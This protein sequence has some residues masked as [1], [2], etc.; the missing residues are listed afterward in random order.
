MIDSHLHL[1]ERGFGGTSEPGAEL[2]DYLELR[3]R[4]GISR[5]LVVGYEGEERFA[6]NND[7][8]CRLARE[9]DWIVPLVYLDRAKVADQ[10]DL[11]RTWLEQGAAGW[12]S[13]VIG[14]DA[15]RDWAALDDAVWANLDAHA[16]WSLNIDPAALAVLTPRLAGLRHTTVL[17]SHL[18]LPGRAAGS[19]AERLA[20]VIG[21]VRAGAHIR[22]KVSG[23]YAVAG[24]DEGAPF[25]SA[26]P[27]LRELRDRIGVEHLVWGSDYTP[28]LSRQDFA[29]Q[30]EISAYGVFSDT[31]LAV[32][33]D[34]DLS[35]V[36]EP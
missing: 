20:P 21:A 32:L 35:R 33:A 26:T 12:T 27:Y 23:L 7:Y 30:V 14:A 18:G 17:L 36:L 29:S 2:A 6:G 13:Y 24:P 10:P 9:Q 31:E 4:H 8:I 25:A 3:Q 15:A 1:F 19:P 11:P 28:V 22:V 5:G 16:A 34:D